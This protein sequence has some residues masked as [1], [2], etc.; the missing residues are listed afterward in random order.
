MGC[1]CI[2]LAGAIELKQVGKVLLLNTGIKL[3]GGGVLYNLTAS[4]NPMEKLKPIQLI[5]F[6]QNK[7]K[8]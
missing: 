6:D 1:A 3:G 4:A 8:D 5:S 2:G 7:S